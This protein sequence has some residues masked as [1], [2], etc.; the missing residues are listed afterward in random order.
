MNYK[1]VILYTDG[2]SRGNPGESGIGIWIGDEKQNSLKEFSKYIG[3]A[4]NNFAEY[5]ALIEGLKLC[6]DVTSE[7]VNAFL[8]SELVVKQL[9]GIYRVKNIN[10]KPLYEQVV[11]L[12]NKFKKVTFTHI[13]REFNKTADALA[14]KGINQK[15]K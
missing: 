14:N 9:N 3:S 2:A 12:K 7:E 10:I 13:R 1:K 11:V 15:I 8:D 4:T 5:T 6:L